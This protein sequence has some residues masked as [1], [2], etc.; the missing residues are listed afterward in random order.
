MED[1]TCGSYNETGHLPQ[2]C[3]KREKVIKR[4]VRRLTAQ[5]LEEERDNYVSRGMTE[6]QMKIVSYT[7]C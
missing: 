7:C 6:N 1:T 4:L 2:D 5:I 3:Q